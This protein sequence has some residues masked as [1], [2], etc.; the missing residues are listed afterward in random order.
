MMNPR[1]EQACSCMLALLSKTSTRPQL[2]AP[3]KHSNLA[4]LFLFCETCRFG[5][6]SVSHAITMDSDQNKFQQRHNFLQFLLMSKGKEAIVRTLECTYPLRCT[7][8]SFEPSFQWVAVT[9]L[10]T[11]IG[12]TQRAI[13]RIKDIVDIEIGKQ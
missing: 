3:Y 13:L 5:L 6:K 7:I 10:Q 9:D 8:E 1:G 2:D 12:T 4:C 11:S